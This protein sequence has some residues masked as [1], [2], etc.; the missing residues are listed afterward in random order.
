[1]NCIYSIFSLFTEYGD[2]QIK[3]LTGSKNYLKAFFATK[4]YFIV[5]W[6]EIQKTS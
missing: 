2:G 1:M 3:A 4:I 5:P 6:V